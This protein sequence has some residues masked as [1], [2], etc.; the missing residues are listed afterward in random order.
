MIKGGILPPVFCLSCLY[1]F[2]M[3]TLY[4]GRKE[5][6]SILTS[7]D[8]GFPPGNAG[9][10]TGFVPP[11]FRRCSPFGCSS[12]PMRRLAI[13]GSYASIAACDCSSLKYFK[14]SKAEFKELFIYLASILQA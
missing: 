13:P 11:A 8:I 5:L 7:S 14:F 4:P 1:L 2:Y 3:I 10:R 6:A 12:L 9:L